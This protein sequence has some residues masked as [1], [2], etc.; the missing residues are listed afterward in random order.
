MST[1]KNIN[2]LSWINFCLDFR[3]YNAIAIIYFSQ[4]TGSYAL[5]LGVFSLR[6]IASSFFELPT[7]ILSDLVGRKMTVVIGQAFSV[8][9]IISY[10]V[11]GSFLI[12]ALGAILEGL[13]SAF[14]S[15]NNDALL[16]DSLKED[17]QEQHFSEYQGKTSSMFQIALGLSALVG[18][19]A[20]TAET[21]QYL[22]WLSV[23][24]QV[25]GF[26]LALLLVEPRK[27]YEVIETNIYAHLKEVVQKF[28]ENAKLRTL[29]IANI[30]DYGLGEPVHEFFP[31]FLATLWPAWGVALARAFSHMFGAIGYRVSGKLIRKYGELKTMVTVHAASFSIGTA[32][33][34]YPTVLTPAIKSLTSFS[35]GVGSVARSSLYQKEFT[36]AQRA[37]MGSL[38]SLASSLFFGVGAYLLGVLADT[39]GLRFAMLTGQVLSVIVLILYW[40][41]YR[42]ERDVR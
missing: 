2:L 35:F 7:G 27:H 1:H 33:I 28:R 40:R 10:A 37:T 12:L 22:F 19:F 5:G 34:A 14:F 39:V 20:L 41:L 3:I 36:D 42:S 30:L 26:I 21:F 16:Y 17:G 31:A 15:G 29:S 23:I 11:G 9:A 8:V 18:A 38:T 13:A 6:T 32:I 24:P 25:I 4:I